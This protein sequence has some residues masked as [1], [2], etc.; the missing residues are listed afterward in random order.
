M[1]VSFNS[2]DRTRELR[3]PLNGTPIQKIAEVTRVFGGARAELDGGEL[4][5]S[6]PAASLSI[7]SAN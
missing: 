5:I 1:I 7:F 2:A 3:V 6:M 4:R